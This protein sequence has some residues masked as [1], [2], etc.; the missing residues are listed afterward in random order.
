M[1]AK[2]LHDMAHLARLTV[3]DADAAHYCTQLSQIL[4]FVEQMQQINTD[5]I[6]PLAHPLSSLQSSNQTLAMNWRVDDVTETNQREH[7]QQCA[8]Q[9]SD[10][11]YV[12]P[13][14]IE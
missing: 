14:V 3:D 7:L 11:F 10:G 9:V 12:V 8:P 4:Q 2:T 13:P 6:E 5:G 1:D